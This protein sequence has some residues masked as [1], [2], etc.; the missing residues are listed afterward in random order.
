MQLK[1]MNSIQKTSSVRACVKF[2]EKSK[3]GALSEDGPHVQGEKEEGFKISDKGMFEISECPEFRRLGFV[4]G[5]TGIL[6]RSSD[7]CISFTRV[8]GVLVENNMTT[9]L[10]KTPE[11]IEFYSATVL[12]PSDENKLIYTTKLFPLEDSYNE[13]LPRKK[14]S[15]PA[16]EVRTRAG[17]L[18]NIE[19]FGGIVMRFTEWAYGTKFIENE[20]AEGDI[21]VRDGSLQTGFKDEILL[22]R[23]LY[24]KGKEKKVYVT[25]LS[26]SCRLITKN[27]DSLITLINI[28]G[29]GKFPN[30]KW[31]YHPIYRI[32]KADNQADVHF[33]KLHKLSSYPFRFDIY[34]EQSRDLDNKEKEVIISNLAENANDLS[35]PGYP[36]GLI[37]VDQMARVGYAEIE[38]LK[39][40]ILSEFDAE[41]YNKFIKPRLRSVDAHD[42][43]NILRK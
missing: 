4:D 22:T 36:Y 12:K 29:S 26:K 8:A 42:L 30:Q 32:T 13:F 19:S 27:G 15:I 16:D 5:G 40:Q 25:G 21:Y 14:I 10:L 17:L 11:V 18:P 20:L 34:I 7:F 1:K 28:I 9:S 39:I 24:S 37:K 6:L 33:V 31:Y 3:K 2:I 23:E 38:P 43:L 41:H 35:F